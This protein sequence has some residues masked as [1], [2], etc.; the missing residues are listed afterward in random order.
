MIEWKGLPGGVLAYGDTGFEIRMTPKDKDT[1]FVLF[2][3]E[4]RRGLEFQ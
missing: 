3:P 1:A 4:G 2:D